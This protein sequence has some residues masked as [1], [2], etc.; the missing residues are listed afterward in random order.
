[1]PKDDRRDNGDTSSQPSVS[2]GNS[3]AAVRRRRQLETLTQTQVLIYIADMSEELS[4]LARAYKCADLADE[5]AAAG[6]T[7]RDELLKKQPPYGRA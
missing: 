1:M 5:L 2:D 7:A 6:G 4:A 3:E